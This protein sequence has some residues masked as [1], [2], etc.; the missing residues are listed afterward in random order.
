MRRRRAKLGRRLSEMA[1]SWYVDMLRKF[2]REI[3]LKC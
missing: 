2:S 1:S 3:R